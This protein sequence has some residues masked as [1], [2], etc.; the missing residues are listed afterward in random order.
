MRNTFLALLAFM[1][2]LC[3]CT[4]SSSVAAPYIYEPPAAGSYPGVIILHTSAG[5]YS[6]ETD[7]AQMLTRQGYVTAVIDY[8]AEGG[9]GNIAKAYDELKKNPKVSG[10]RIGL[11]G[12]SRG[13]YTGINQVA[14]WGN[15]RPVSAIV[16]YYIGPSLKIPNQ[17][18]PPILFLHGDEDNNVN[19]EEILKYCDFQKAGGRVCQVQIYAH[20]RHA[21][22][23]RQARLGGYN[24]ELTNLANKKAIEFLNYYLKTLP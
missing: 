20:G 21:F 7:Y 3:G 12:F 2:Q 9:V 10:Q 23:H 15:D 14:I 19:P 22:D 18:I 16:S 17:N 24:E 13:A 1:S 11:V 6:H 4:T 8:F 5:L